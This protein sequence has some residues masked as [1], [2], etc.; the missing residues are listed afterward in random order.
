MVNHGRSKKGKPTYVYNKLDEKFKLYHKLHSAETEYKAASPQAAS[1]P[2]AKNIA[3]VL[4]HFNPLHHKPPE[5]KKD[6]ALK[7]DEKI[8]PEKEISSEQFKAAQ[9]ESSEEKPHHTSILDRFK[10]FR[11][12]SHHE[13]IA[14][15]PSS[16]KEVDVDDTSS[17]SLTQNA[18]I[19]QQVQV[20]GLPPI[21]IRK[22]K[23]ESKKI[24]ELSQAIL[25][26][27]DIKL[28]ATYDFISDM[29]PIT[30][31]IYK[32]KG[33]FVPIYDV[34]I[35]SISKNTEIILEKIREELTAQVN[36]GMVDILVTKDTGI[37]EQKFIDT[38]SNLISKHFPDADERTANFLKSYLIQRSLGL[39]SI[40]ILMDDVNL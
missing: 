28:I 8:L 34:S 30:I 26:K 21:D 39:G 24:H 16:E 9:K 4:K 22:S 31:K 13:N 29:I 27:E 40:E 6:S 11:M 25:K 38:I 7:I 12:K 1:K 15:L 32:K 19:T 14:Q 37:I 18:G 20:T 3:G 36:L 17:G 35:S 33:E 5:P 23:I 10:N 2:E